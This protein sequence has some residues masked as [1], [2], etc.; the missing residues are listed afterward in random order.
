MLSKKVIS[1]LKMALFMRNVLFGRL[2]TAKFVLTRLALAD[3]TNDQYVTKST[4]WRLAKSTAAVG[5]TPRMYD[6]THAQS[7]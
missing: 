5:A 1:H 3:T 4:E 6:S 2:L 7:S